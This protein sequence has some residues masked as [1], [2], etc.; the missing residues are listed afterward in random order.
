MRRCSSCHRYENSLTSLLEFMNTPLIS[1][2][3]HGF[4]RLSCFVRRKMK[5]IGVEKYGPPGNFQ[6]RE[7][8]KPDSPEG[9]DLLIK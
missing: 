1:I 4:E 2:Q 8:F 6:S 7:I 3:Q 9:R 5:A